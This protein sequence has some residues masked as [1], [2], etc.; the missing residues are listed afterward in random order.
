MA[1]RATNLEEGKERETDYEVREDEHTLGK[2]TKGPIL[3]QW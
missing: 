3:P 2:K 1:P